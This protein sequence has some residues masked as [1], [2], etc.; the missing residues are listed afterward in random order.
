MSTSLA[1]LRCTCTKR[2]CKWRT[3]FSF[4]GFRL[5]FTIYPPAPS[6]IILVFSFLYNTWSTEGLIVRLHTHSKLRQWNKTYHHIKITVLC[7]HWGTTYLIIQHTPCSTHIHHWP[8]T[9]WA[10]ISPGKKIFNRDMLGFLTDWVLYTCLG[11]CSRR[12]E[13]SVKEAL[14]LWF[15]CTLVKLININEK[16]FA[17]MNTRKKTLRDFV[18]E[19]RTVISLKPIL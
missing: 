12:R 4:T 9:Y 15:Y 14:S 6:S 5:F 7:W 10:S 18:K 3:Q 13:V 17:N 11:S 19:E 2:R 16:P 1:N 8:V